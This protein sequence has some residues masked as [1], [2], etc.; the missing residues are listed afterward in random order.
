MHLGSTDVQRIDAPPG[1]ARRRDIP[2]AFWDE[3]SVLTMCRGLV[4]PQR[5]PRLHAVFDSYV[6]LG[7]IRAIDL[8]SIPPVERLA[9]QVVDT[10]NRRDAAVCRKPQR[11]LRLHWILHFCVPRTLEIACNP[12]IQ[13]TGLSQWQVSKTL[14]RYPV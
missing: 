3:R 9:D 4:V 10:A 7:D 6:S 13:S 5:K 12:A 14:I 8:E 2:L 11:P 1:F